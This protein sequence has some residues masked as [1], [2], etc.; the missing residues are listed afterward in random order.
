[1]YTY[2]LAIFWA[3]KNKPLIKGHPPL[4]SLFLILLIAEIFLGY[5]DC[6]AIMTCIYAGAL[7][8]K[9]LMVKLSKR[10]YQNTAP[11]GSKYYTE[12][13]DS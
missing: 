11:I 2:L 8:F 13:N 1:M 12:C 5:C 7:C 10:K 6:V 4:I 3:P 9:I